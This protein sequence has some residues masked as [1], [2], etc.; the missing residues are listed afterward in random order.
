MNFFVVRC[1]SIFFYVLSLQSQ[2][3]FL[4]TGLKY[5]SSNE[6][7]QLYMTEKRQS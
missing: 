5:S 3:R 7:E 1:L 6:D 2:I 4:Y